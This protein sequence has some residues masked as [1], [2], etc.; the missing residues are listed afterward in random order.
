VGREP[1][2]HFEFYILHFAFA[3]PRPMPFQQRSN[4]SW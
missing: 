1:T 3:G 4:T 2:W